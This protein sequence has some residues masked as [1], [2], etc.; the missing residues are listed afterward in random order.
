M[1]VVVV[2]FRE[3][4][5]PTGKEMKELMDDDKMASPTPW[6]SRCPSVE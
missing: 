1:G 2:M 6:L 5:F 3:L 4:M